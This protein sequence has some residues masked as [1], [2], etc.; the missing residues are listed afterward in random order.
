M[1]KYEN[2]TLKEENSTLKRDMSEK[3]DANIKRRK[4]QKN[5]ANR[6]PTNAKTSIST[7][8]IPLETRNRFAPLQN[9]QDE[10]LHKG[11]K[12]YNEKEILQ[13]RHQT[14]VYSKKNHRPNPVVNHFPENDN[15][16]WEQRT[17][18][19]NSKYSDAVRNVKKTFIVGTSM[20][21]GIRMRVVNSQLRNSFAKLRSFPGATLKHLKYYVAPSL[22]E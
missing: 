6:N 16:F 12:N 14:P 11:A 8:N 5:V 2:K 19:G 10:V 22:I 3:S 7:K 20:V 17:V 13:H 1:L 4:G 15:P 21:K 18:S 9:T